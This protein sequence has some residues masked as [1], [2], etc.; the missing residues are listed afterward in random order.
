MM[1]SLFIN[2]YL[3]KNYLLNTVL[4][5]NSYFRLCLKKTLVSNHYQE[6]KGKFL[7]PYKNRLQ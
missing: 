7:K 2:F 3:T 6:P 4:T 1:S 5:Y